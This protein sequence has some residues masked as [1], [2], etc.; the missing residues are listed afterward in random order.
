[1]IS[2]SAGYSIWLSSWSLTQQNYSSE[3]KA[4][5]HSA[6]Q[7]GVPRLDNSPDPGTQPNHLTFALFPGGLGSKDPLK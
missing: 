2:Y 3:P 6:I 5:C 4:A 7:Q 1:M